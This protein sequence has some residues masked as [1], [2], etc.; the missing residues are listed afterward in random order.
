MA[1][2]MIE[3]VFRNA[4]ASHIGQSR[5]QQRHTRVGWSEKCRGLRGTAW[6]KMQ[7]IAGFF[8]SDALA[9]L[10]GHGAAFSPYF[11]QL[12]RFAKLATSYPRAVYEERGIRGLTFLS[13]V[14]D[15][16]IKTRCSRHATKKWV[17]SEGGTARLALATARSL[18]Q[19]RC[20]SATLRSA[21]M[22]TLASTRWCERRSGIYL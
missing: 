15:T 4:G 2:A 21:M 16:L 13:G 18:R 14:A 17:P 9:A 6:H 3:A 5:R 22:V 1:D 19:E 10:P 12:A 20:C 7:V 8:G 11:K